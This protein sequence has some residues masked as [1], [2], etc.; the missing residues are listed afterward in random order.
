M[1]SR[2]NRTYIA[3][4]TNIWRT[5]SCILVQDFKLK[6]HG[7]DG[8]LEESSVV[9]HHSRQK[10]LREVEAGD[11]VDGRCSKLNPV[12]KELEPLDQVS[13]VAGEGFQGGV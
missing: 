2:K 3:I 5:V 10:R 4:S 8:H 1:Q 6:A 12:V 7:I 11:P 9:L 13:D